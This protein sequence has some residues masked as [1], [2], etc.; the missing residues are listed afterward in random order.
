MKHHDWLIHSVV[1][2]E[3]G[4][5]RQSSVDEIHCKVRHYERLTHLVVATDL[6]SCGIAQLMEYR[7]I[8]V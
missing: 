5:F 4:S 7:Y 6:V 1:A 3:P 2:T 8:S